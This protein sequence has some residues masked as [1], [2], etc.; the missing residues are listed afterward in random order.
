MPRLLTPPFSW[1]TIY[2]R[3]S[4]DEEERAYCGESRRKMRYGWFIVRPLGGQRWC[5]PSA[6][7]VARASLCLWA[8]CPELR[9]APSL[10]S[11][12]TY[13]SSSLTRCDRRCCWRCD[14]R[15]GRPITCSQAGPTESQCGL[16]GTMELAC[17]WAL[18]P[19]GD[20][21]EHLE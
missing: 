20:S 16:P 15:R 1:R 10:A 6:I 12:P 19:G 3:G 8:F 9:S 5:S 11:R 2:T 21:D 18:R 7:E 14:A 4:S 17:P 13:S